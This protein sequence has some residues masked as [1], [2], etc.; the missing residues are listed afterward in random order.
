MPGMTPWSAS[1]VDQRRAR[2]ALLPDRLVL[3]DDAADEGGDV[4]RAEEHL[5]VVAAAL[6]GRFDRVRGQPLGDGGDRLVR[7]QDPFSVG[8]DRPRGRV[9]VRRHRLPLLVGET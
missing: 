7:G 6:G 1:S 3:Q 8:N 9:E 2:R 4:G 5:A